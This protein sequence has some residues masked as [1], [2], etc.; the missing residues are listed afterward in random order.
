M[1]AM[2]SGGMGSSYCTSK[3]CARQAGCQSKRGVVP[4][5]TVMVT[6]PVHA[7]RNGAVA[8]LPQLVAR[9]NSANAAARLAVLEYLIE[10][11]ARPGAYSVHRGLP[12][13]GV[14]GRR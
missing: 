2:A 11:Y 7:P 12:D 10:R 13:K 5:V 9:D 8:D 6:G 3:K 1:P 4:C 14:R